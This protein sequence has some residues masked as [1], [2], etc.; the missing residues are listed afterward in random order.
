MTWGGAHQ[1]LVLVVFETKEG[2]GLITALRIGV[3]LWTRRH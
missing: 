2:T 3:S 1:D